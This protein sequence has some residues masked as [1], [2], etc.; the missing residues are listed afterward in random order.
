MDIQNKII[1]TV[2]IFCVF[3]YSFISAAQ[4]PI[5]DLKG[6]WSGVS[7]LSADSKKFH[8]SK[9]IIRLNILK[10]SGLQFS[11]NIELQDDEVTRIRNFSGFLNEREG[12]LWYFGI[13]IQDSDLN[14]GYLLT[15]NF[16]KIHLKNFYSD[17][18]IIVGRLKREKPL[19]D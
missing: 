8:T 17:F 15:K 12:Y 3:F 13:V 6:K 16:M 4:D 18:E 19:A 7:Y 14:I 1:F 11:G 10:Q 5:P 9:N 2:I